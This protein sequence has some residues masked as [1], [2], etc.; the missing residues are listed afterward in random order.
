MRRFL[1]FKSSFKIGGVRYFS[2]FDDD[3]ISMRY[4][5]NLAHGYGLRWNPGG[6]KVLS[7]TNPL[8][9]LFYMALFH[10][11]PIPA[12]KVSALHPNQRGSVP[13]RESVRRQGDLQGAD[14]SSSFGRDCRHDLDR[15]LR[16]T[17]QLGIAGNGG[18][19][20]DPPGERLGMVGV[21]NREVRDAPAADIFAARNLDVDSS[22]HG[23]FFRRH[24]SGFGRDTAPPV[25]ASLA[26]RWCDAGYCV[27]YRAGRVESPLLCATCCPTPFYLK[28][29]G[30]PLS[31]RIERGVRVGFLFL[32]PWIPII[33][34][35]TLSGFRTRLRQAWFLAAAIAAQCTYS[36]WV[37]GDAWEWYGGSNRYISI[38]IPLVF[39][40]GAIGIESPRRATSRIGAPHLPESGSETWLWQSRRPSFS[41]L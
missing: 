9:V 37:G 38:A 25:V 14:A 7:F 41:F 12:A 6:E 26:P 13:A 24:A 32:L 15:V 40:L 21:A 8:W 29:T 3:M 28:M 10:L 31:L 18:K 2:L 17:Q 33:L 20:P 34:A 16:A 35:L 11:L 1:F 30:F 4:A 22:R 36:I 19:H 5:A 23:G 39:I 27:S